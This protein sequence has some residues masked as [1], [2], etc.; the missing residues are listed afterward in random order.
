MVSSLAAVLAL[1]A[2]LSLATEADSGQGNTIGALTA[3]V[4]SGVVLAA[5]VT[6]SINIWQAR[7]KSKEEERNRLSAAFAE[8]FAAYSAYNEM[9][10]AIRRRRRD[11]AVEERFRLSEA[12]REIQARLAYHEAWT[13]VESEE[14]GKAYAELLQQMRRTSGVA[15]HDAWL[16]AANR[17]D[18]AMNI[19]FSVVDLRSLKPYEQAYLEAVRTHLALLTPWRRS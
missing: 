8:A 11:Q 3:T 5:L 6:A 12:L 2:G 4:L 1:T 9:P 14:V 10:F 19:P 7:R 13:A 16:A 17:S 18:V 15:M